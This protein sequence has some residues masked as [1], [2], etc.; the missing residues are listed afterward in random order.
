MRKVLW[1]EFS[2][3]VHKG[4]GKTLIWEFV[5]NSKEKIVPPDKSGYKKMQSANIFGSTTFS[6]SG[7]NLYVP[8]IINFYT[9]GI[10]GCL[11]HCKDG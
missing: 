10:S 4:K 7:T 9:W 2:V 11:N 8:S 5:R 1:L 3:S 6:Y